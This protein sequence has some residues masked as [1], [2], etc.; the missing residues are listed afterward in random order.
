MWI[1][2]TKTLQE[3]AISKNDAKKNPAENFQRDVHKQEY[4]FEKI[5]R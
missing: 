1:S 4:S 2:L 5:M 3:Y